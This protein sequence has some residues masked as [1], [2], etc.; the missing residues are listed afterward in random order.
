MGG[1]PIILWRSL[2]LVFVDIKWYF[3]RTICREQ[4]R[5]CLCLVRRHSCQT[6]CRAIL[7]ASTFVM[8]SKVAY[9][10]STQKSISMVWGALDTFLK[11]L[12]SHTSRKFSENGQI[13]AMWSS[14]GL[15]VDRD[16]YIQD[17][18]PPRFF[19]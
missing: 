6:R 19:R 11:T 10:K 18:L 8:S 5:N 15:R 12:L 14:I 2:V 13:D 7:G 16:G 4:N 1:F 3:R 9:S 17:V